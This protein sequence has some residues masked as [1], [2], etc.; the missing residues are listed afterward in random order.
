[1]VLTETAVSSKVLC[2]V[3]FS[4]FVMAMAQIMTPPSSPHTLKYS[5]IELTQKH[6]HNGWSTTVFLIK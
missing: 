4:R 6:R 5:G 3:M 1:M 2:A